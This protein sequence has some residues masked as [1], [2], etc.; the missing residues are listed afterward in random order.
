MIFS[1]KSEIRAYTLQSHIYFS[2]AK[3]LNQVV[4]V[5]YNGNHIFWTDI[6]AEHESIV[7]SLEDGSEKEVRFIYLFLGSIHKYHDG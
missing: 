6:F 1:S 5:D 4:G 2:V 7:R 3:D